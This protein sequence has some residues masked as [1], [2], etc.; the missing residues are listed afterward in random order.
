MLEEGFILF[1]AGKHIIAKVGGRFW[2]DPRE[3]PG[4]KCATKVLSKIQDG[5]VVEVVDWHGDYY[6]TQR[7]SKVGW[8]HIN[9]SGR[10]RNVRMGEVKRMRIMKD[11]HQEE[12]ADDLR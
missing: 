5:P 12:A 4:A 8:F 7:V 1:C 9:F 6:T 10:D 11:V 3:H 2:N